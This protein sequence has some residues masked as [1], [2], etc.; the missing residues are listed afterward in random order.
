MDNI[1]EIHD[2]KKKWIII[3]HAIKQNMVRADRENNRERAALLMKE[4]LNIQRGMAKGIEPDLDE[5]LK[6]INEQ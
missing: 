4:Y 6:R 2:L 1:K 3:S 5:V